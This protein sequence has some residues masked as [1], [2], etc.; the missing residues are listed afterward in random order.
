ME[1]DLKYDL[2]IL[3]TP[4]PIRQKGTLL[5]GKFLYGVTPELSFGASFRYFDTKITELSGAI[6]PPRISN[7][8][9]LKVANFGFVAK[10]DTRS[11]S[12]FPRDGHLLDFEIIG[13]TEVSGPS[14]D[15][16][17]SFV[18]FSHYHSLSEQ[19]VL[20]ARATACVASSETPFFDLCSLGGTDGFRG[21]PATQYYDEALLS[22]QIEIRQQLS[23]RFRAVAFA[24]MGVTGADFGDFNSEGI[25]IAGGV[26]LRFKLSRKFDADFS[27][28]VAY[29]DEDDET[30]YI[31]VGQRF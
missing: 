10:W 28:D 2:F 13:G 19:T 15:Y 3:N 25:H 1:G 22:G 12:L 21:F 29:N 9:S 20:A 24:G 27:V 6:L 26:G 14:R 7:S 23:N 17:K 5:R 4:F 11:D 18:N 16:T 30:I 31:Y 8:L